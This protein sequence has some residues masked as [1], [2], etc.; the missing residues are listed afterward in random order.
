M[1]EAA[2]AAAAK[3]ERVTIWVVPVPACSWLSWIPR[4]VITA[5]GITVTT[6]P[7]DTANEEGSICLGMMI[8]VMLVWPVGWGPVA[9]VTTMVGWAGTTVGGGLSSVGGVGGVGAGEGAGATSGT[10]GWR[11]EE[12]GSASTVSTTVCKEK[13]EERGVR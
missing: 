1:E 6:P 4:E 2:A 11:S 3:T 12:T 9:E 8:F 7:C 5:A 13:W 10:A